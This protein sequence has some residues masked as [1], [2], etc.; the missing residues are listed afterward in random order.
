MLLHCD[1]R[2]TCADVL[3]LVQAESAEH[4]KLLPRINVRLLFVTIG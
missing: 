1:A 2:V 4:E 3:R